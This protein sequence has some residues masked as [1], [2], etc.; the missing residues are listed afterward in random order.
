MAKIIIDNL[1]FH[2]QRSGGISVVWNELIKRI[3]PKYNNI[4]HTIQNN[5]DDNNVDWGFIEYEN[6]CNNLLRQNLNIPEDKIERI[7]PAKNML[8]KR[9]LPIYIKHSTPFIFHSTYYRTC[10]NSKAI[11]VITVHDFTYEYYNHGLKRLIHCLTKHRAIKKSDYVVCI[12]D[13]TKRD[14]IRFVKGIDENK[15]HVIYN[16]CGNAFHILPDE[17]RY[18]AGDKPFL[19]FVGG[20][21]GYKNFK[22]AVDVAQISDMYLVIVGKKLSSNE[23]IFVKEKLGDKFA[24]MGFVS[25]KQLNA[26][27]NKAFALLYPSAYEGFGLPVIEAQKAG[28]PV[29]AVNKSS[30]PEIIGNKSTLVEEANSELFNKK[31]NT[32]KDTEYRERIVKDGL[33]NSE[34][35]SWDN[36]FR[37]YMDLYKHIIKEKSLS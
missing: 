30:I 31:I 35:F 5:V 22:C 26:I 9:Y 2:W 3:F 13:N 4:E 6:S 28:C 23:L 27:Y 19:V 32:L 11:N 10:N 14:I 7:I 18:H 12:S 15:L 24:D 36:T 8:F 37:E 20:R 1:I 25:D 34:K 29:L 17:E 21:D 33:I 16:G